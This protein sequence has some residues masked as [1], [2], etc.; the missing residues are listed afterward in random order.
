[1]DIEKVL[2]A[3][4]GEWIA[5]RAEELVA[6]PSPTMEEQEVCRAYERMLCGLGLEVDVR[7]VT[8]GRNNL[9][10]R[11]AGSGG[12][13][14]L[15]LNGHLDT[16]A[17]GKCPPCKREGDRLYG[18]G[19]TDMKGGMAAILG[20]ARGLIESGVRLKG[21]LWLTAVVGHEEPE[22]HKDGPLALVEDC[23]G[24]RIGG[25]RILIAEGRDAL[26]VMSMGSM[27]FTVILESDKGGKHTQYV[28]L[29][30]NP[31]RFL[32]ELIGRL[33]QYQQE[34]DQG[35]RHP[36]AGP[37]RLDLGI[38]QAGDY[39]NRTPGL[40]LLKGTRRW[41][42]GRK[43][44][45]VLEELEELA[46][47]FAQ[48]GSLKLKV[49]MEHEREPFETPVEDAAVQAAAQAHRLVT[50]REAEYLGMRIV[51]DANLYVHGT[52]VP[53]FYY[54]PA[55]ETAH[56]DVEWVSMER[57]EKAARVYALTAAL[58]CEVET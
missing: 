47:P 15:L 6:I 3:I 19:A 36:L 43:A 21:D 17:V 51:G 45:E 8:P 5:A 55:N 48:A 34:L 41:M 23:K 29:G 37:E 9:Y 1:M 54:G 49:E 11:L 4:D 44:A 39:F 31:I 56:A 57:M 42:P 28:S 46:R 26:W 12:G 18:R 27:V 35:Q 32:G 2:A 52:G 24:G 14:A 38:A 30:E 13:P 40:C 33:H 25:E 58:Y 22:A 7:E 20:A 53:T 16:I 50:G 10:A